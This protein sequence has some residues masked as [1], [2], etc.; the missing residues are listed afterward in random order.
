MKKL[1]CFI[2]IILLVVAMTGCASS[3]EQFESNLNKRNYEKAYKIYEVKLENTEDEE[4]A[5]ELFSKYIDNLYFKYSYAEITYNEAISRLDALKIFEELNSEVDTAKDTLE[6]IRD[7]IKAYERASDYLDNG[8]YHE[9]LMEC[10]NIIEEDSFHYSIVELLRDDI[11]SKYRSSVFDIAKEYA[12]QED[13][14]T[15][16]DI[17][18]EVYTFYPYD[19]QLNDSIELYQSY[20]TSSNEKKIEELLAQGDEQSAQ[21]LEQEQQQLERQWNQKWL[22]AHESNL[23]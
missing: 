2:P 16:V 7:S 8:Q 1:L 18:F 5:K 22:E 23:D 10:D 15:A 12:D 19:S 13:Y 9:A 3:L 11:A 20:F 17:L 21:R 4:E 6:R 14:K